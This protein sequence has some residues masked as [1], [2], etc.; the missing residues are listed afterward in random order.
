MTPEKYRTI[1]TNNVTKTYRKP[2]Q[3]NQLNINREAKAISKTI[4]WEKRMEPYAERPAFISLTLFR[5]GI[6]GA[7]KKNNYTLSRKDPKNI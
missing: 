1:L 6:F 7:A 5:M 4:E 3:R 2:A